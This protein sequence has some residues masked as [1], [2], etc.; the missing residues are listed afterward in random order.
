MTAAGTV[1]QVVGTDGADFAHTATGAFL[2]ATGTRNACFVFCLVE[3]GLAYAFAI[4]NG[5]IVGAREATPNL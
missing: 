3:A 2:T 1:I 4:D 5:S